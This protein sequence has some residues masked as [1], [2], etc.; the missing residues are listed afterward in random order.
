M[1]L[2]FFIAR[3]YLFSKK[4]HNAINV[5][6]IISVCGIAI[7][8]M[9]MVCVL[10]VFNGFGGVVEGL[11]SAFDPELKITARQGKVFDYHT[12]PFERALRVEGIGMISESLEENALFRYRDRQVPVR[13]KGVSEEFRLLAD[14][15]RILIDGD[16]RL[17]EDV[18]DYTSIG[19]GLAMTLGI[20]AGYIDPVEIYSPKRDERVNLANPSSA[21]TIGS[22]FVGGVFSL[23]QPEYDDQLAIIPI[24]LARELLRYETEVSSLDIKLQAGASVKK[25]KSEIERALGDSY[26]VEDRYEQQKES[27]RMLQIEKWVTF[28]ILAFILLIAVFNVVGSLLMLIV[29]KTEDIKSLRNMGAPDSLVLHVFLYEGWLI[30]LIGIIA[31]IVLGL[32]LCLLQQHFGLI[33]LSDT[34]G[35]YV[36]DAYPVIVRFT[37]VVIVFA[38]VSVICGLTVLYPVNNLKKK[39]KSI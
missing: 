5:I 33:R 23:N 10:S 1:N 24:Q 13:L 11:F 20:R 16:F 36:V 19:A 12:P 28:L 15:D 31:G 35:A 22:A 29:E 8:T 34:P 17:R 38:I 6:S 27:Y 4:S 7:A 37:D 21:F 2:S 30:S 26:L 14:M 9:A 39:L 18:V 3:R 32:A 25:V